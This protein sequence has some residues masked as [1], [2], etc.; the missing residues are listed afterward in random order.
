MQT[1]YKF[2][3]FI[4]VLLFLNTYL[5]AQLLKNNSPA[6]ELLK[7]S[8]VGKIV[9]QKDLLVLN[10]TKN[11]IVNFTSIITSKN[12]SNLPFLDNTFGTNGIVQTPVTLDTLNVVCKSVAMQKDGKIVAAGYSWKN[13]SYF[14][15]IIRYNV[16][17]TIDSSF[18]N[19]GLIRTQFNGGV[20]MDL[21]YAM[22]IQQDGKIVVVGSSNNNGE[23]STFAAAR[24]DT[25][26]VLDN[27]FGTNGMVRTE[28]NGYG[29]NDVAYSVELQ[30]DGKIIAAGSTNGDFAVVRYNTNGTFDNTFGKNGIVKISIQ[31]SDGISDFC[32][33]VAIQDDGKIV[34]GGSS[35]A[36]LGGDNVFTIARINNNG[37]LDSSFGGTG[38][39][40]IPHGYAEGRSVVIQSNNKIII[41]GI[42]LNTSIL[43]NQFV[44]YRYNEDGTIDSTFGANGIVIKKLYDGA[45]Y[46]DICLASSLQSDGKLILAGKSKNSS[47]Y[48]FAAIR[49]DTTGTVD[50]SFGTYGTFTFNI[51]N[52]DGSDDEINSLAIQPD[53][54]IIMAGF[55]I[56][57]SISAIA[58]SRINYNGTLDNNFG[59]N[60]TERT[61]ILNNFGSERANSIAIQPDGKIIAAGFSSGINNSSFLVARYNSDGTIDNSFG[62]NGSVK[63]HVIGGIGTLDGALDVALQPDGKIIAVGYSNTNSGSS[64]GVIRYNKDGEYDNTFGNNGTVITSINGGDGTY[65]K[66]NSI[67]IQPDGKIV[68][69]GISQKASNI[70]YALSRYNT[71]GTLDNTFGS[72]GT[73][74]TTINGGDGTQDVANSVAIQKDG[75][76]VVAGNSHFS[77]GYAIS[78]ARYNINGSLDNTFGTKGTIITLPE[79]SDSLVAASDLAIQSNGKI[80]ITGNSYRNSRYSLILT[81]YNSDGA[82][83]NTFGNEGNIRTNF[84]GSDGKVDIGASIVIQKDG[85]ILVGGI[86]ENI[87]FGFAIAR[88]NASGTF[89]ST[90]ADVGSFTFPSENEFNVSYFGQS[91]VLQANGK[92]IIG[93]FSFSVNGMNIVLARLLPG[94]TSYASPLQE[95]K[96]SDSSVVLNGLV[97]PFGNNTSV[98]FLY[99]T[100]SGVYTDS[101]DAVPNNVDGDTTTQIFS[102]I[103]NLNSHTS[104]YYRISGRNFTSSNYF[105][106]SEKSFKTLDPIPLMPLVI[107]PNGMTGV[108]RKA[109]VIWH[110][111]NFA[112]KYHFQISSDSTFASVAFDTTLT[113]TSMQLNNPLDANTKY[114]WHVSAEDT[115]GES[116]FSLIA[117]FTTST[118]IIEG[119]YDNET[120]KIFALYQNYPNPFN[121]TTTINYSIAKTSFVTLTIYDVLGNE[122]IKLLNKEKTAGNYKVKFNATKL[123]SGIY[124]YRIQAGDFISTKKLIL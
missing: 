95:T 106:S 60:G 32:R 5:Q 59:I 57:N 42:S 68:V 102:H 108:Y 8:G 109:T 39:I 26:G 31:G 17:G 113:D 103:N 7:I 91:A 27:T 62:S 6:S 72:N 87:Q 100:N 105:V 55:S 118:E 9:Q 112:K 120:P 28:I 84:N 34:L 2:F 104:Y 115:S 46:D 124:F 16:N 73:I 65:D 58:V 18:G 29:N 98:R 13:N 107:S 45:G 114:Y 19:K 20:G 30:S 1:Y 79:G 14:F 88:F 69:V 78:L 24:Y 80:I 85:K 11:N 35:Y 40:R 22:V 10:Q 77:S 97:F 48:N 63:S 61:I 121:P 122:V 52:G 76:I 86:S 33:S 110:T 38:T 41:S 25:N 116:D 43:G 70:S 90:F 51:N 81:R 82:I 50:S 4:L 64:F 89:D 3:S 53:G 123:A 36:F 49:F 15:V 71:N 117:N 23:G 74:R 21:G 93:G 54:K 92:I 96:I 99:G 83:D 67:A 44:A 119:I 56:N 66:A 37:S 47:G 94:S 111:S 101:I 12:N 75:K